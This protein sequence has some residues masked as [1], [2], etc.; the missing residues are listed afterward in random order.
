V[1]VRLRGLPWETRLK[2]VTEFFQPLK[3]PDDGIVIMHNKSGQGCI[4]FAC[5]ADA[6]QAVTY[7]KKSIGKRYIEVHGST[8]AEW[9]EAK[10]EAAATADAEVESC[11]RMRGLP[12]SA[13]PEDIRTFLQRPALPLPSIHIVKNR[14]TGR[15]TGD[16]Y[17][18]LGTE[19]E[20]DE[21]MKLDKEKIGER[22]ID[23]FK[24]A[25]GEVYTLTRPDKGREGADQG[26]NGNSGGGGGKE[27]AAGGPSLDF[28]GAFLRLHGLPYSVTAQDLH[29]FFGGKDEHG[30]LANPG[31]FLLNG[32]DGRFSGDAYVAFPT[33]EAAAAA[34]AAKDKEKIGERY[35]DI[36]EAAAREI[37]AR[38]VNDYTFT[39]QLQADAGEKVALWMKG[40]PFSATVKDVEGFFRRAGKK[41]GKKV[42]AGAGTEASDSGGGGGDGDGGGAKDGDKDGDQ[43]GQKAGEGQAE[44]GEGGAEGVSS[45]KDVDVK[46]EVE[47]QVEG[48]AVEGAVEDAD[49]DA[50]RM[51]VEDAETGTGADT[52]KPEDAAA[53]GSG[54]EDED[55]GDSSHRRQK[56]PRSA[57]GASGVDEDEEGPGSGLEA[58]VA[59]K[60][61]GSVNGRSSGEAFAVFGSEEAA[62]AA[63]AKD[64]EEMGGRWGGLGWVRRGEMYKRMAEAAGGRDPNAPMQG[65][66]KG[67]GMMMMGGKGAGMGDMG[68]GKGRGR[69]KGMGKGKGMR[70]PGGMGKGA[71]M[72][73]GKGMFGKGGNGMGGMGNNMGGNGSPGSPTASGGK[74]AHTCVHLR[75]LPPNMQATVQHGHV[76]QLFRGLNV[77][78]AFMCQDTTGRGGGLTGEGFFAFPN[79]EQC[80]AACQRGGGQCALRSCTQEDVKQAMS[81]QRMAQQGKGPGGKGGGGCGGC[82]GGSKGGAVSVHR[83]EDKDKDKSGHRGRSRSRSRSRDRARASSKSKKKHSRSRSRDRKSDSRKSDSR[84]SDSR[85]SDRD[86]RR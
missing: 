62:E 78:D 8:D 25:K 81:R 28:A 26:S 29:D 18:D 79:E 5:V 2:D 66:G 10:T 54:S 27:S 74:G 76:Q 36:T 31:A 77:V 44:G 23:L 65:K 42:A 33:A 50:L 17:V 38:A 13:T 39:V 61:V 60:L 47:V 6:E 32:H 51:L 64:K 53:G 30:P 41:G 1:Y 35:V 84:K 59:V 14:S 56:S 12:Y 57:G 63:M 86:R 34:M 15:V 75:G 20:A 46:V 19:A 40:L 22:W 37:A 85:K 71:G 55:E 45:T 3:I 70:M 43:D 7:H 72:D 48:A 73:G 68:G 24:V 4:K 83:R 82:G 16:A 69:G 49:A 9:A 80:R 52:A 58:P 67:M 11:V 21:A